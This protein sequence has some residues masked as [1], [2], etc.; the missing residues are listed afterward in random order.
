MNN[1][2]YIIASLPLLEGDAAKAF[3]ADAILS[4]IRSQLGRGDDAL[5]ELLLESSGPGSDPA[6]F[7]HKAL[8]GRNRFLKEYA[9]LELAR[10]NA[11]AAYVNSRLGR[12]E[13]TDVLILSEDE[14]NPS[15]E[16]SDELS[17]IFGQ[18]DILAR[19][20]ALDDFVWKAVDRITVLDVFDIDLILAFVVKLRLA[21]RWQALD[22]EAG[23]ELFHRLVK[24]MKET[25]TNNE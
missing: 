5:V 24:E 4:E 18:T 25:R 11:G 23:R 1:Y 6:A 3:D 9:K 10:R 17:R 22:G 21:A 15:V 16:D 8:A 14:E 2:E 19:E 20:K 12:P 7:C 13:G